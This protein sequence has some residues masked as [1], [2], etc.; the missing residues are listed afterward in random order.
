MVWGQALQL[1]PYD[2][3]A[4]IH[5]IR[6]NYKTSKE[7]VKDKNLHIKKVEKSIL[8]LSQDAIQI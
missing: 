3:D 2:K 6:K 5:W 1:D 8:K 4:G 7:S